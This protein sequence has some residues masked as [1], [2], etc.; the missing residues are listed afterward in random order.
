MTKSAVFLDR[1]GVIN[2]DKEYVYKIDDFIWVEGAIEAIKYLIDKNFYVF[3]V[4]NQSGIAR[5]YYSEHDVVLLHQ[6]INKELEKNG[7]LIHDFYYSPYHPDFPDLYS[8]LSNLR[9][10]NIGMLELASKKWNFDKSKSFMVGN[11]DTDVKCAHNYGIR[12]Y[13]YE[14]GNLL[15]FIKQLKIVN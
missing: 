13:L 4:T 11:Q 3:V 2:V 7:A 5:G 9:K 12:G 8:N 14:S 6:Y 15:E 1:D 10:P